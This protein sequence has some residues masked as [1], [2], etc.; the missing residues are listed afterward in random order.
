MQRIL[1]VVVTKVVAGFQTGMDLASYAKLYQRHRATLLRQHR[2][3]LVPDHP[4]PVATTWSLSFERVQ[5]KNPA[6][7]H[8][9]RM[10][11]FLSPDAI[12]EELFTNGTS[13]LDFVLASVAAAPLSFN[14][15]LEALRAYSLIR[16]NPESLVLSVHRLVQAVLQDSLEASGRR[17]WAEQAMLAINVVF[18]DVEPGTWPQCERLLPHASLAAQWVEE[19]QIRRSEAGRLLY[20]T[21]WYLKER[22]RYQEAQVLYRQA[23]HIQEQ[24]LGTEHP[25]IAR[26]LNGL[27]DFY[28]EQGEYAEAEPLYQRALSIRGQ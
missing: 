5:E 1:H 9:L 24:A 14:H 11:A 28:R 12:P 20:V 16:R 8:L 6:A 7:A 15:A 26:L 4:A 23:F 25:D 3:G 17:G 19:F 18:P 27:A 21:A 22:A 2:G 10:A 13:A